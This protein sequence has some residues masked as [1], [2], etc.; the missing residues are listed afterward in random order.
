L[1]EKQNRSH[2]SIR[3]ERKWPG[4]Q[5]F[6]EIDGASHRFDG[7]WKLSKNGV[8]VSASPSY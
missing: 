5:A 8:E 6:L 1:T 4:A 2:S 7:T 3:A